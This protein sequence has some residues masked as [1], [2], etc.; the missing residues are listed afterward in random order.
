MY[1]TLRYFWALKVVMYLQSLIFE[2]A[3][4]YAV[5]IRILPNIFF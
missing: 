4:D 2:F 3:L 1:K 5:F